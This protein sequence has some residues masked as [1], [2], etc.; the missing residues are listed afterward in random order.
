MMNVF[1]MNIT[2]IIYNDWG[3]HNTLASTITVVSEK[4]KEAHNAIMDRFL[5]DRMKIIKK[6]WWFHHTVDSTITEVS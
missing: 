3:R 1:L 6:D 4:K 5:W 2:K